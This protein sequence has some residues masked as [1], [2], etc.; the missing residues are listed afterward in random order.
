[1]RGGDDDRVRAQPARL[2][3]AHRRPDAERL[4]LVARR[5]HDPAAD[6]HRP[7]AQPRIV[8]LLDRRVERVEVG[9][10]DP[11]LPVT[12]TYVRILEPR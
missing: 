8:P 6:D 4:G 11:G 2:P 10:Q 5:E 12:R 3:A 1:M 9:V 7:A